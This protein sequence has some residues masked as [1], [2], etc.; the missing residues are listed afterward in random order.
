MAL[1][2]A[3]S[4]AGGFMS[5]FGTM[6]KPLH[7]GQAAKGGIQSA[8]F[9]QDGLTAGWH[10]LDGPIGMNTL[11]VGPDRE[12]LRAAIG[13]PEHGQTLTF[14]IDS[15][16]EPLLILEHKFRVKRFPT[17]G[18][19]HR[20]VDAVLALREEHGFK[21]GDIERVDV[22][23]GYASQKPHVSASRRRL[24]GKVFHRVSGCLCDCSW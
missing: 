23:P 22:M 18:S 14:Q 20:S 13:E 21:A 19:A 4:T 8:C 1:S 17:C 9:A 10:T 6:A 24:A 5:Q 7:A 11:M 15:I 12:D 3:T 2:L 16:G